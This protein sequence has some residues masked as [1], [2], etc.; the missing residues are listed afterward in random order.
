MPNFEALAKLCPH[1][2]SISK[3]ASLTTTTAPLNAPVAL[4]SI[5]QKIE[6]VLPVSFSF[7]GAI[8]DFSRTSLNSCLEPVK[9]APSAGKPVACILMRAVLLSLSTES[10][11]VLFVPALSWSENSIK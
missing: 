9:D 1:L 7:E 6:T 4:G 5:A 8:G 11:C 3:P 2:R 10:S